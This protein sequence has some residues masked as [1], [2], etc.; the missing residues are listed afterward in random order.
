MNDHVHDLLESLRTA[1]PAQRKTI[2]RELANLDD[3]RAMEVFRAS[4][5]DDDEDIRAIGARGLY[6]LHTPDAI[7]AL[8]RTIDDAPDMLHFDVTPSATAL[9][10]IGLRALP[11]VLPLLESP[12]PRTRQHAQKVFEWVLIQRGTR[13]ELALWSELGSFDWNA[14]DESRAESVRRL[15]RWLSEQVR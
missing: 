12:Q 9:S 14:S 10:Q 8:V 11:A 5:D 4:L 1:S 15:R 7:D 2:L 6:R 13:D 3:P